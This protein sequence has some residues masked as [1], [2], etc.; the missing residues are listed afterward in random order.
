M[1][2]RKVMDICQGIENTGISN[3]RGVHPN[4]RKSGQNDRRNAD[5]PP[6]V[7]HGCKTAKPNFAC[8]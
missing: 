2:K 6:Q 4:S 1:R 8:P 3:L 7:L 5:L